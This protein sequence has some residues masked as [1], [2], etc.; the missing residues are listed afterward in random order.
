MLSD[1]AEMYQIGGFASVFRDPT[2]KMT[3][4]SVATPS[5]LRKFLESRSS[6]LNFGH[7]GDAIWISF[8]LLNDSQ[9]RSQWFISEDYSAIN[10]IRFYSP[11]PNGKFS[12]SLA[13]LD[14]PVRARAFP[15]RV[16]VF[17]INLP[18]YQQKLCFIRI[19]SMSAIPVYLRIWKPA[20][21]F[22]NESRRDLYFGFFYGALLI[23]AFY[24]LFLFFS[25][26]DYSYL[27]YFLYA[28]SVGWYQSSLDGTIWYLIGG[29]S[30]W[31]NTHLPVI[32]IGSSALFSLLF[33]REFL[34]VSQIHV[35]LDKFYTLL[36]FSGCLYIAFLAT[37]DPGLSIL[38]SG[39]YWLLTIAFNVFVGIYSV[40]NGDLNARVF[41][42][43]TSLFLVGAFLRVSRVMGAEQESFITEW[44]MQIGIL[45]EMTVLSFALGYRI[46]L[47]RQ[48]EAR[49]KALLRSRIAGDLHDEI[50]SNLSSISVAS[51]M[52]TGRIDLSEAE[53]RQL[54][55]ITSTARETADSIRDIIWFIN[56]EHDKP[57]DLVQRMRDTA[58]TL[59]QGMK[60]DFNETGS[61]TINAKDLRF[62]RNLYL[63]FKEILTN[64]VKHSRASSVEI[65]LDENR[66]EFRIEVRTDGVGFHE[67]RIDQR[68]CDGMKNLKRRAAEMGCK[69]LISSEPGKGTTVT[70]SI[71]SGGA[72]K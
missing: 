42:L 41:L 11:L 23:M 12:E 7:T 2:G 52:L 50:G 15:G 47:I 10:D 29:N 67:K 38:I 36:I 3:I 32:S 57:E 9:I 27:F 1:T 30:V 54:E 70:V 58:A 68:Q 71:R 5:V 45:V 37:I 55:E 22:K 25:V 61:K 44:G 60:V 49:E 28:I 62:R 21:F 48:R 17:P 64:I 53:R 18:Q 56:P 34:R 40:R 63:I 33:V 46:N 69:L 65:K 8:S 66:S 59:L 14:Y 6:E 16:V 39:P 4:D 72:H 20:A 43:A 51:Q 26:R 31:M 24:N 35:R 13:G 19:R